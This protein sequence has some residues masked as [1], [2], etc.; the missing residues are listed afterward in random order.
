MSSGISKSERGGNSAYLHMGA[1]YDQ[2]TGHIHLTVP[3]TSWFHTTVNNNP[4]SVRG[5]PNLYAKLARALKEA[6]VP[7]PQFDAVEADF[8]PKR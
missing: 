4:K 1:W 5:N 7:G 8:E 6:G 3:G 2:K